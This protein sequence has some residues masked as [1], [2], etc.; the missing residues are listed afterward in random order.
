M[1]LQQAIDEHPKTRL[2]RNATGADVR[3]LQ[4]T[5]NFQILHDIADR[6]GRNLLAH[7]AG[8]GAAANRVAGAQIAL[9]D[10]AEYFA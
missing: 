8:Q 6:G 1:R 2:G 3:G 7:R 9:D 4:Q 10:A 5:Q